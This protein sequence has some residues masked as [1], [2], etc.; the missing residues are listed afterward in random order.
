MIDSLD[1]T[2]A[3]QPDPALLPDLGAFLSG[4]DS[5]RSATDL[6]AAI[7][8]RF[9][10]M[11][12]GN[13]IKERKRRGKCMSRRPG[14]D[15]STEFKEGSWWKFRLWVDVPGQIK[16]AHPSIPICPVKG[17]GALNKSQR[18]ARKRELIAE[19]TGRNKEVVES[20]GAITFEKQGEISL[21]AMRKRNREP[22]TDGT[23]EQYERILRLHLNPVIG[24]YPLSEIFNPQLKEVVDSLMKKELAPATMIKTIGIA[25]QVVG[26]AVDPRTG[27]AL[28]PRKWRADLIDLPILNP[29]EQYT[30]EFSREILTG[31]AAYHEPRLRMLFTLDGA[32]G[33]RIA[34]LLGLEIDKHISPDFRTITIEQQGINSKIVKRVKKRASRREVDIHPDISAVLKDFV[35][36][37]TRGLLFATRNNTPL[38]YSF[39]LPHLQRALKALGYT[40]SMDI[41]RLAGTH[42]F[43]RSRDTYLRNETSCPEGL[44]KFWLGH[45]LGKDM[46]DRYDKI[47]RDRRKRVEWAEICGYGFSLPQSSS[48][49]LYRNQGLDAV[50]A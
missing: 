10:Q 33:A 47:K 17:P 35:G 25:K 6:I 49:P 20:E 12:S 38:D 8:E 46:S 28:Y 5:S 2:H 4:W 16:R 14:Q 42:A 18:E 36:E 37:R 27:E 15:G 34:E 41:S 19:H 22:V 32:T 45:A 44:Y 40:D 39:V 29:D 23:L 21:E 9:Q 31:L 48:V 3:Q 11:T 43:R 30:P 1:S 26:S 24:K 7:N 50:A 13:G